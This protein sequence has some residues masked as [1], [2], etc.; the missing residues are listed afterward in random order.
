MLRVLAHALM[1]TSAA[2]LSACAAPDEAPEQASMGELD[3]S[4]S[5]QFSCTGTEPFWNLSIDGRRAHY[6]SPELM[7]GRGYDGAQ[8][9]DAAGAITYTA[10]GGS[11]I[12]TLTPEACASEMVDAPA[13]QYSVKVMT[14][15]QAL[16]GCCR[17]GTGP[18]FVERDSP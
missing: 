18:V 14:G 15:D 6:T 10:T 7:D 16:A 17:T 9:A 2:M 11:L 4:M 12:A 1:L 5:A 8:S 13:A 3:V